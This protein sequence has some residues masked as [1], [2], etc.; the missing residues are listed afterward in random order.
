VDNLNRQVT[1][2]VEADNTGKLTDGDTATVWAHPLGCAA[3]RHCRVLAKPSPEKFPEKAYAVQK[4]MSRAVLST[5]VRRYNQT[6]REKTWKAAY[7][8]K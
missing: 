4:T 5:D 3:H 2:K 6:Q 1:A 7:Q 8:S